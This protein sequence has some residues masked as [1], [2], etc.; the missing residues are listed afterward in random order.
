MI[1]IR[2]RRGTGFAAGPPS[3]RVLVRALAGVAMAALVRNGAQRWRRGRGLGKVE[4]PVRQGPTASLD[5]DS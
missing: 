5:S 2:S 4:S 3:R 1:A